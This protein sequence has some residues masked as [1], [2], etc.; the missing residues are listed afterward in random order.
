MGRMMQT[1]APIHLSFLVLSYI[2]M[3]VAVNPAGDSH[4]A[5]RKR[6]FEAFKVNGSHIM[7]LGMLP[8][9]SPSRW[10]DIDKVWC[11][12]LWL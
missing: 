11:E 5:S 2:I 1:K 12:F 6:C 10:F 7:G 8:G 3:I 9:I 4:R